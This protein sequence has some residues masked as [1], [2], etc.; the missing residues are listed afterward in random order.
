MLIFD[1][2]CAV[3][4]GGASLLQK[5]KTLPLRTDLRYQL[6]MCEQD[7]L[8]RMSNDHNAET[9]MDM[10]SYVEFQ[11]HYKMVMNNHKKALNAVRNFWQLLLRHDVKFASIVRAFSR[12]DRGQ[13]GVSKCTWVLAAIKHVFGMAP[14]S[15]VLRCMCF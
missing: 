8:A 1:A 12:I 6:Y 15:V 5:A 14:A 3:L 10:V 7:K 13:Y 2:L 4:Q 9:S 11:N